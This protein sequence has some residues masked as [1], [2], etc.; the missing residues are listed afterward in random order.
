[1]LTTGPH[2]V[3]RFEWV[4]L[5]LFSTYASMTCTRW[6]SSWHSYLPSLITVITGCRFSR[7]AVVFRLHDVMS[8]TTVGATVAAEWVR[9]RRTT[10][11]QQ[12]ALFNNSYM[13]CSRETLTSRRIGLASGYSPAT[14]RHKPSSHTGTHNPLSAATPRPFNTP[15]QCHWH[16]P[17]ISTQITGPC[18]A[19]S[20]CY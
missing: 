14:Q 20:F 3:S 16:A 2:L 12:S 6:T 7:N 9:G 18:R 4:E 15:T 19:N 17:G 1:M 8:Q 13:S 11:R 10:G 5:C